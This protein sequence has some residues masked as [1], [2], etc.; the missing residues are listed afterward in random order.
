MAES[1]L[2]EIV[3]IESACAAGTMNGE[4]CHDV[5]RVSEVVAGLREKIGRAG[6]QGVKT[7]W[8]KRQD[9][10]E[11]L[12]S[13]SIDVQTDTLSP[14]AALTRSPLKPAYLAIAALYTIAAIT[15]LQTPST[16]SDNMIVPFTAQEVWWAIRDGYITDLMG[17]YFKHGGLAVSD[18]Y[19]GG[20]IS[21]QEVWWSVRDGYAGNVLSE[22]FRNGGGGLNSGK[23]FVAMTPQ[24]V[25][26]SVR[27]GYVSDLL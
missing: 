14:T 6:E 5:V 1:Y 13:S 8:Q 4:A 15:I 21:P 19:G 22:W 24:E 23:E 17:A 10:F 11:S 9:E 26:W 16:V 20:T 27:D 7:F 18:N 12:V 2:R 25:W 3:R